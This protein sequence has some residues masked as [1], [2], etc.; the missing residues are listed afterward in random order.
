[1][2][3]A[4]SGKVS[5][6]GLGKG[7]PGLQL[8]GGVNKPWA[9][10][11]RRAR[12]AL[13]PNPAARGCTKGSRSCQPCPIRWV[14]KR[15]LQPE[16]AVP[17]HCLALMVLGEAA[18]VAAC[19]AHKPSAPPFA[20]GAGCASLRRGPWSRQLEALL[21]ENWCRA[22][23]RGS[24]QELGSPSLGCQVLRKPQGA[25]KAAGASRP[26][27]PLARMLCSLCTAAAHTESCLSPT[28]AGPHPPGFAV[29]RAG[30]FRGAFSTRTRSHTHTQR[31]SG[32]FVGD[33]PRSTSPGLLGSARPGAPWLPVPMAEPKS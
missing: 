19:P 11:S 15:L 17:G 16:R 5:K 3:A 20:V 28:Q 22:K 32:S 33:E 12:R 10:S 7:E 27:A 26:P 21:L 14:W 23:P 1:M 24:D 31:V 25:G 13:H 4:S 30:D 2:E 9:T 6:G 29:L 18:G 8:P